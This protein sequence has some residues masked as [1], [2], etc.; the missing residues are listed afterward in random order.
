MVT[1]ITKP[2]THHKLTLGT[3]RFQ[4]VTSLTY[5]KEY[6]AYPGLYVPLPEIEELLMDK[7]RNMIQPAINMDEFDSFFKIEVSLPGIHKENIVI[8]VEDHN[9]TVKVVRK[10]HT[11]RISTPR[12]HEFD[13]NYFE[14]QIN[15]PDEADTEFTTAEYHDGILTL[16]VPKVTEHSTVH[17]N[18]IVVY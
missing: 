4:M 2:G 16:I 1:I 3:Q 15:L 11:T 17:S 14:R 13:V 12:I 5:A 7:N 10:E 9:L 8:A 18:R 6:S